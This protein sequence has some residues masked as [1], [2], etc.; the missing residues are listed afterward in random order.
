M[1]Q[2]AEVATRANSITLTDIAT[3]AI[4]IAT[5]I[6]L[7]V[8]IR[9]TNRSNRL[10]VSHV[11]REGRIKSYSK[12]LAGFRA[13]I[14]DWE[15]YLQ[16]LE[17]VKAQTEEVMVSPDK[18]SRKSAIDGFSNYEFRAELDLL[19]SL[20][21]ISEYSARMNELT[22][23]AAVFKPSLANIQAS[24]EKARVEMQLSEAKTQNELDKTQ[25][26]LDR[27]QNDL[28]K[29]MTRGEEDK[30]AAQIE[31][32]KAKVQFLLDKEKAEQ[33]LSA[34]KAKFE[35]DKGN[36][37]KDLDRVKASMSDNLKKLKGLDALRV[38]MK[39]ELKVDI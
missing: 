26:S 32:A 24:V 35:V 28:D 18:I 37:Q 33:D 27:V 2:M 7:I 15:K 10:T 19:G 25:N 39:N 6:T 11:N 29:D 13:L 1:M 30:A 5:I 23:Y 16:D 12:A 36:A 17:L 3:V 31:L 20:E 34:A 8:N 9:L 21:V 38:I 22:S 4:A 14:D